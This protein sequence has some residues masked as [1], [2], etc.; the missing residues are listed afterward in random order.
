LYFHSS[1]K[2]QQ[3]ARFKQLDDPGASRLADHFAAQTEVVKYL[4]EGDAQDICAVDI[5]GNSVLHYPAS[6]RCVKTDLAEWIR[7]FSR[8]EDTWK[9]VR[10]FYGHTADLYVDDVA[11]CPRELGI[12]KRAVQDIPTFAERWTMLWNGPSKSWSGGKLSYSLNERLMKEGCVTSK[13]PA[14]D[15]RILLHCQ[16]TEMPEQLLSINE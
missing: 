7:G 9:N 2:V 15:L 4:F 13:W 10:I 1:T 16:S 5:H 8:A 12:A 3:H 11:L 14:L 6:H